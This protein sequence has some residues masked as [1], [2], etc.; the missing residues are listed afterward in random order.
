MLDLNACDPDKLDDLALC[1]K[2]LDEF[3]A[4]IGMTKIT[5]PNVFHYAGKVPEDRGI[6]GMVIIAESHI[7]LHTFP[8]RSFA[9]IDIFSCKPFDTALAIQ[10]CTTL[11][12]AKDPESVVVQRGAKF[13]AHVPIFNQQKVSI[14]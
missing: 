6:T 8:L 5:Q 10:Y 7:S 11:F 3:P 2:F 13:H 12:D 1:A 9:F 4:Q 14:S